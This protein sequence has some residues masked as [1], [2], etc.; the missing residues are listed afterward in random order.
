MS[1]VSM[2]SLLE[3]GVHFGHQTRRWNPKM[4]PYIFTERN[5]IYI[6]DLQRTLRELETAYKF[7]RDLSA[8]GDHVLFVGTK[9]QAQEPIQTE[10]ERSAS[11]YVNQRWL[12]G[13]L[14]NF[15]TIRTR[16]DRLVAL[17]TMEE[18][19]TMAS[20]P[21]KE[22]LLL[23]KEKEKLERNLTGIREMKS[24]PAAIF[25]IDTK[26]ET[27][28]VAEARRLKIPII[29]L[30]DTNADP[31]E[32][33]YIIPG[34][35][36]AIRSVSLM[37]RVI[38]D[39][40][41]EGRAALEGPRVAEATERPAPAVVDTSVAE[42]PAAVTPETPAPEVAEPTAPDAAPEAPAVETPAPEAE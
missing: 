29:G 24:L 25:V 32:L 17:E 34:N 30:A 8:R 31:D 33:D 35:D 2:K 16:I 39:A 3:A 18:D 41:I 6:L 9:K 40:V 13:M 7:V 12:G 38:A 20:L 5:G 11:P 15:V 37:S 21:K 22:Q 36:D 27:I 10:A 4:K 19:G 26:R 28:A 1:V 42:A 14:T 23:G